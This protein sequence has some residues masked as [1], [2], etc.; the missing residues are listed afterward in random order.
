MTLEEIKE[1]IAL[2]NEHGLAEIEFERD[3]ERVRI[4]R[5]TTEHDVVLP[6]VTQAPP[7]PP[8]PTGFLPQPA[9][10]PQRAPR[11]PVVPPPAPPAEALVYVKAPIVGTYYESPSPGAEPFIS[12]GDRVS[13]GQVLCII[14]SMK[15]MNEI[16]AEAAGTVVAKLLE[17]GRPVEYGE[18]LFSVKPR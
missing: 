15:L 3:G 5:A 1:L 18:P 11:T 2:A 12:V 7:Q 9:A 4:R 6:P 14:E 10:P 16:E 13:K 17:N 8:A